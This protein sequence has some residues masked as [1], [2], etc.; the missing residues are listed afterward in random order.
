VTVAVDLFAGP[1]GWDVAA[2]QL[3]IDPLGIEYDDAACAT[4][5]AAG[6]LTLQADVAELDPTDFGPIDLVIASAPCPTFSGAGQGAGRRITE[7]IVACL[8]DLAAA[9]SGCASGDAST[10]SPRCSS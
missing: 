8:H 7:H 9:V 1:G 4:R 2:R 5:A 10:R 3:G 6:L